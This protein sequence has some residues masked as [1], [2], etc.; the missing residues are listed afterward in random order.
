MRFERSK[1]KTCPNWIMSFLRVTKVW[2]VKTK[3]TKLNPTPI[4]VIF[5]DKMMSN[6]RA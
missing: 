6:L 1:G 4:N 2:K 5:G 3:S